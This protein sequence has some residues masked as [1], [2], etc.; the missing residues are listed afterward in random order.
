MR[1]EAHT[2][3]R[4]LLGVLLLAAAAGVE[5]VA[6]DLTP[7]QK[8]ESRLMC[9]CGCADL[10]VRVCTCGTADSIRADIGARLAGGETAEQVIAAFVARHGEKILSAP[11]K[12]GFNLLAWTMPFA[13]ILAAGSML[14]IL[15]RRWERVGATART[16]P[17]APAPAPGPPGDADLALRERV[18]REIEERR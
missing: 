18:R 11:T 16:G 2:R 3:L 13:V 17:D 6:A 10:T 12:S 4:T 9:Y 8:I 14:V 1:P 15:V 5:A 7:Q